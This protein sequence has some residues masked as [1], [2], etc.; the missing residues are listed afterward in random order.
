MSTSDSEEGPLNIEA[1]LINNRQDDKGSTAQD[2]D[3]E[4][5]VDYYVFE[6][7]LFN[8]SIGRLYGVGGGH[9]AENIDS[10][11]TRTN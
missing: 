5:D 7:Y 9:A 4:E 3:S 2:L 1:N 6:N 10:T 11:L 8:G